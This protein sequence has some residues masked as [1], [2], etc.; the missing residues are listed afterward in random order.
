MDEAKLC[1]TEQNG[2][3]QQVSV[4]TS[5]NIT[6]RSHISPQK[7]SY[8]WYNN[9]VGVRCGTQTVF[10]NKLSCCVPDIVRPTN[11]FPIP[12]VDGRGR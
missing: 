10:G 12:R 2:L 9:Q 1:I 3:F 7:V 6:K 8:G 5:F 4:S 11:R